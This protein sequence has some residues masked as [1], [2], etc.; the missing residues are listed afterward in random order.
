MDC[1]L[2]NLI[3]FLKEIEMFKNIGSI[4][5]VYEISITGALPY[6]QRIILALDKSTNK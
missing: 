3:K 5:I 4:C 2:T 6:S 1:E